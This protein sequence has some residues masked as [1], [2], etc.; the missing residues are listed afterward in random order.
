MLSPAYIK[1]AHHPDHG[2]PVMYQTGQLLPDW[3]ADLLENGA[4]LRPTG[5]VDVF[6]LVMPK[7]KRGTVK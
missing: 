7:P 5:D 2:E 4:V 1:V 3:V 6:D